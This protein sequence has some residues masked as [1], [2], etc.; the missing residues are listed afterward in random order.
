MVPISRKKWAQPYSLHYDAPTNSLFFSDY[1]DRTINRFDLDEN[2]V[3]TASIE[4]DIASTFIIPL[5]GFK[6]RYVVS[7]KLTVTVI[8][9]DGKEK[10]AGIVRDEFSVEKT[11][12]YKSN[13]WNIA[14]ASP[15]C[16]FYGGTFRGELC[17]ENPGASAFLYRYTRSNGPKHL[18]RCLKLS[19]GI[20]WNINENLFY[21][22]DSCNEV[23]REFDYD[24]KTG[25]IGN[26][27]VI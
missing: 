27:I 3:Y 8:E 25:N 15:S 24:P 1:V 16:T 19:G 17:S 18:L 5:K 11:G 26:L 20:D 13:N 6:N 12:K 21:H 23:I 14:K 7:D 2:H 4:N 9:W 10:V 22:A